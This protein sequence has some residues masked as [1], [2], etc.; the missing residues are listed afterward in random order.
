MRGSQVYYDDSS[1]RVK[2]QTHSAIR[3]YA[4]LHSGAVS[5]DYQ[6]SPWTNYFSVLISLLC[7]FASVYKCS[8]SVGRDGLHFV[9]ER[10]VVCCVNIDS[11]S[12]RTDCSSASSQFELSRGSLSRTTRENKQIWQAN[13]VILSRKPDVRVRR[14]NEIS[15]ANTKGVS[16]RSSNR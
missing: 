16:Q 3:I 1:S 6:S 10:P 7:H 13:K 11:V 12:C 14:S 15:S 5:T 4:S 9:S 8:S 2:L